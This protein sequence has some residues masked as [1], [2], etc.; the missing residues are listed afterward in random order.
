MIILSTLVLLFS[1]T[2]LVNARHC[3][4]RDALEAEFREI[5][6]TTSQLPLKGSCCQFDICGIPCSADDQPVADW[7]GV[8][9]IIA[10]IFFCA[11]GI[12]ASFGIKGDYTNFFVGGRTLSLP[13]V[14]LTLASQCV[15][16]NS[17][18]GNADLSYKYHF[19]DG[20]CLPLG[21][22]L[23]LILNGLFLAR[24][25]NRAGLLTLPDLWARKYG[26]AAE[27]IGGSVCIVSFCALLAGNLV[28]CGTILAF[29]FGVSLKE[30]I[31]ISGILMFLY[32]VCGG[33]LSVAYS[34]IAQSTLGISGLAVAGWWC[35]N[36]GHK[37][38][39]DSIG[40][41]GYIYP[42]SFG[43]R[44]CSKYDGVPCEV[45]PTQCC[46]NTAKWCPDDGDRCVTDNAAYWWKGADQ[47]IFA[48]TSRTQNN[49]M[50]NPR[51]L[52][53]FPNA[54]FFNWATIFILAFGNLAAIDFQARCMAAKDEWTATWGNLI[55]G[56]LGGFV[57]IPFAFIGGVS[58]YYYGADSKYAKFEADSCSRS[59]DFPTCAQWKP[60]PK[61]NLRLLTHE[62]PHWLGIWSLIGIVAASMSTSDGAILAMSTV[63]A[64]NLFRRLPEFV[65][66]FPSNLVTDENLLLVTRIFGIPC[67]MV[68]ILIASYAESSHGDQ[69]ATGYLLIVAFD[70]SLAACVVPIFAAFYV[71]D[72]SPNAGVAAMLS[73]IIL[74]V[75]LEW[76]L[77][78][79]G[80]L[81]LPFKTDE[82]LDYGTPKSS[83][84]PNFFDVP[85]D[86][87]WDQSE[88][89]CPQQRLRDFTGVDSLAAPI[90][91]TIVFFT[92]HYGE[93]ATGSS[94]RFLPEW[95]VTPVAP[96]T[97]AEPIGDK[98]FID[99]EYDGDKDAVEDNE[100]NVV[101][102]E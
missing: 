88:E 51:A 28:G 59:V 70:I 94:W 6:N 64:H 54:I 1:T 49:S 8:V 14:T 13:V 65:P 69:S 91:A 92:V 25:M 79:D 45:D 44:V 41:P 11:I 2:T 56:V 27:V 30:G 66:F 97:K 62:A 85:D 48:S 53:P 71:K 89:Q 58:R 84:Y 36:H 61:A 102:D 22:G 77:P 72:A 32:T 96:P 78:K 93:K 86:L 39:P 23:S 68:S 29:L 67:T 80:K 15:D 16:S 7:Y 81:I 98:D 60:D 20:A 3:L 33:I 17:V 4:S 26:K 31:L 101:D 87:K 5:L 35:F 19:W 74:R 37:A 55:A 57:G 47:R 46:Y 38:P 18:L 21:L 52:W 83:L 24:H 73:G 99:K 50:L 63:A 12:V 95:M 90:F 10:V 43:D 76:S 34:D 100:Y 40:F 9:I 42:D 75:I 82:F